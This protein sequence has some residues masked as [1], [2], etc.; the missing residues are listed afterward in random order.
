MREPEWDM[1]YA[2]SYENSI[3][4]DVLRDHFPYAGYLDL[5]KFIQR[6]VEQ[7]RGARVLDLGAGTGIL[8]ERFYSSGHPVTTVDRSPRMVEIE[9]ERM[10][11]GRQI[12]YDLKLGM[13]PELAGERFDA[14]VSTYMIAEFRD[15]ELIRLIRSLKNY[16]EPGGNVYLGGV[17]FRTADERDA[18]RAENGKKWVP[19]EN[20]LVF[21]EFE[22]KSALAMTFRRISYCAGVIILT[23]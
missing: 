5:L 8:A 19:G 21:E 17:M 2:D 4:R 13:P 9:S 12:C 3:R 10:R 18:C 7:A 23:E 16:L 1:D 14:I 11:R 15:D 6:G 20:Y 22:R